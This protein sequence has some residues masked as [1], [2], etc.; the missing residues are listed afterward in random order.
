MK[1]F[2]KS[3]SFSYSIFVIWKNLS[4][5]ERKSR[6]MIDIRSLNKITEIDSY[7]LFLQTNII[8]AIVECSY[9]SIIDATEYFH[10]FLVRK[11][12]RYKF[13]VISH[14]DQEQFSVTLI[15]YNNSLSYVQR[16]TNKMLR[17]YKYF[18]KIFIDDIVI[19]F[20]TFSKHFE[21]LRS[22]F[23]LLRNKRISIAS[24]K[25][26]LE[27]SSIILLEQQVDSLELIIF[28]EKIVVI[29]TLKFSLSLRDLKIFLDIIEWL[30]F[31]I[32]RYARKTKIL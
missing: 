5:D 16:Q 27:Y 3:T 24:K 25:F 26:F 22:I 1:W 30:R 9:I 21:H 19:F 17:S 8:N 10:Q 23:K 14:R 15:S 13:I 4:F 6:A 28:E 7:S 12:N 20:K 18:A 32:E 29:K 11:K 2:E 31:F